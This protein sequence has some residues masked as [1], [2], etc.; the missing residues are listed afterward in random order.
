MDKM[1]RYCAFHIVHGGECAPRLTQTN[2]EEWF[3]EK[4]KND[5]HAVSWRTNDKC[6]GACGVGNRGALL[7]AP[8]DVETIYRC[9]RRGFHRIHPVL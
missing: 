7:A 6:C 4:K 1:K 5:W 8:G 3:I 9:G 2:Y